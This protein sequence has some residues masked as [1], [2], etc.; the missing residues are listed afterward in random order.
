LLVL[1]QTCPAEL[2]PSDLPAPAPAGKSS[3]RNGSRR[4]RAPTPASV[5]A[6]GPADKHAGAADDLLEI[7][8]GGRVVDLADRERL[9]AVI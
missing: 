8:V 1:G 4:A 7:N 6:D 2:Q 3:A 5:I 9:R